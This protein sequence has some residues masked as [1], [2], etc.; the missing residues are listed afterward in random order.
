MQCT[1]RS[2]PIHLYYYVEVKLMSK[3]S[4]SGADVVFGLENY[5]VIEGDNVTICLELSTKAQRAVGP[6]ALSPVF[7]SAGIVLCSHNTGHDML[8]I[9]ACNKLRGEIKYYFATYW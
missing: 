4:H 2:A 9:H 6:F 8:H 3:N 5:L 1:I 7:D